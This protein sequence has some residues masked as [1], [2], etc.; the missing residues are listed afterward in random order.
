MRP[1][2]PRGRTGAARLAALALVTT[3]LAGYAGSAVG[4]DANSPL[5]AATPEGAGFRPEGLAEV[6]RLLEAAVSDGAF[7]G[8]VLAVGRGGTLVRFRAFGR[9]SYEAGAPEVRTDTVYDLASL[10]KVVVTTT[11]AMM[12]VDDG[13]LDLDARVSTIVPGFHGGAKDDVRV[14]QLLTHTG[15][16]LWWAPLY[17]EL[18]GKRAYL[19]RIVEMD[20]D[21]EPGT[22]SVYSDLGI[23]LLAD[24]LERVGGEPLEAVAKR[25][26]LEPLG[27]R[28]TQY[29]PPVA[30]RPRIAPTERDPWRGRVLLGEVHDENAFAL[31]GVAPHAGLFSTAGDLA[32]F[33]QALLNGGELD[34]QRVVSEATVDLFTRRAGVAESTRA[35]G[36]DTPTNGKDSR[37]SVPGDPGYSSSGSLFSPRSFGHTGFTGTSMWMDPER[38]LFAHPA[39]Q[40][41]APHAGEPADQPRPLPPGRRRGPSAGGAV[42]SR[43]RVLATL[44]AGLAPRPRF[45]FGGTGV[46]VGLERIEAEQGGALRGRRVGLLA[47]A[48]SVTTDGRHAVDVLRGAGVDVRRLFGPEHGPRGRAAAGEEVAS[49]VDAATGLPFVSLYGKKNKPTPADVEGLD[50]LVADLQ[51]AGVRFYTYVS[52]LLLCLEAAADAGIEVCVLDRPDPLGGDLVEGPERDPGFPFSLVSRAPGPL[53]HG[54]TLGEMA[55]YANARRSEPARLTVVPMAGW[56][57]KMTWGDTGRPWVNP[58]PNLRSGEAALL[59]PGTCLLEATNLSEGR[60]TESPFLLFGAPWLRPRSLAASL[61]APGLALEPTQFTPVSSPAAPR[62]KHLDATCS[63]LRVRVTDA[64]AARPYAF[65]LALLSALRVQPEFR[66]VREGEWL[67]TL[68]GTPRVREALERGDPVDDILAADRPAIDR[69]RGERRDALLY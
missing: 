5:P 4:S 52:T 35:L 18:R 1:S 40:P 27:M 28:D 58:S 9:L 44:A 48:A 61:P 13:R 34:G 7:P 43:R 41:R 50:V 11:V 12:L 55:R 21:Y 62:P 54:L 31:E 53:V 42:I 30:L 46:Q 45:V 26:L 24:V 65:G 33:A 36:W 2:S 22:K 37:S 38:D 63:G 3:A 51:D 14:R 47:H 6:D 67:D 25:R 66:W 19:D 16:L 68:L 29:L 10:T 8:A 15:G 49:G 56:T 69:F 32:R 64:R 17:E 23:M 59:Y 39:H 57:R 60:G 20:L